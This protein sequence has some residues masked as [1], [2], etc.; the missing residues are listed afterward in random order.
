MSTGM[1]HKVHRNAAESS[2]EGSRK[3]CRKAA[4]MVTRRII[5]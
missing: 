1:Q 2:Q 3:I 4:D 5:H